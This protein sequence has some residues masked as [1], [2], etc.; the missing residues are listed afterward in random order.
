MAAKLYS[1]VGGTKL[2][3]VLD[4]GRKHIEAL[5]LNLLIARRKLIRIAQVIS[6]IP[7]TYFDDGRRSFSYSRTMQ[8]LRIDNLCALYF[9]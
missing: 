6:R 7:V 1:W 3:M 9:G 2:L 5:E 4:E 8:L